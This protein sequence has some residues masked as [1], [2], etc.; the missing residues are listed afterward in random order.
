MNYDFNILMLSDPDPEPGAGAKT[1]L[2][3]FQLRLRPK[4]LAPCG[5]G[6]TTLHKMFQIG[7]PD[8]S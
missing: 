4:V 3:R 5:S 2:Y 8:K 6:T 1:S 7:Q